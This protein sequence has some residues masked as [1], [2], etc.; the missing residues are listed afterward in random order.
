MT[1]YDQENH[2]QSNPG[3]GLLLDATCFEIMKMIIIF[4]DEGGFYL[5]RE[6][7]VKHKMKMNFTFIN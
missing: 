1:A 3:N 2:Q 4:I 7:A 5:Q 6:K